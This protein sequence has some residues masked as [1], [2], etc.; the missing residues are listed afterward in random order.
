MDAEADDSW[1]PAQGQHG[2]VAEVRVY[3]HEDPLLGG[4][5]GKDLR[6]VGPGL[7]YLARANDIAAHLSQ[8]IGNVHAKHLVEVEAK[9]QAY[10]TP[11]KI[12]SLFSM[13]AFAY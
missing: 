8:A 4:C 9:R 2:P 7:A 5:A 6:I 1:V 3:R 11:G 10:C 12:R 13:A